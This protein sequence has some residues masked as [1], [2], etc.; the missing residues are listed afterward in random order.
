RGLLPLA[1]LVREAG[2]GPD[3]SCLRGHFPLAGQREI[4][5][6]VVAELPLPEEGWRLDETVHPFATAIT[7]SDVRLTTRYDESQ[8]AGALF[9]AIH[10]SGHGLYDSGV[11]PELARTPLCRGASLGFHES[12]SRLWE[13]W[14][15]RGR[16]FLE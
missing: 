15:G 11:A 14:V 5:T 9:G 4:V 8:F 2:D 10:E 3:D 7:P 1:E 12:Q 6:G 13:N 16:P